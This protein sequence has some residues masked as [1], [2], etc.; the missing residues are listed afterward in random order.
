MNREPILI[1]GD[2]LKN[3]M[4]LTTQQIWIYNQNFKIPKTSGLFIVLQYGSSPNVSYN[5]NQFVPAAEG[6]PT[7]KQNLSMLAKENYIINVL[8]KDDEARLRKEEVILSLNSDFA[9]NQQGVYQ[10]QI[11]RI[12]NGFTNA[13]ELEGAGMLNRFAI[14]ISLTAHYSKTIDTV[15]YDDFTNQINIE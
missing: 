15:L 1:I 12:P 2:I 10:F 13:S 7:A 14:N 6:V 3:C 5:T 11:A 4:S 9:K 8:S